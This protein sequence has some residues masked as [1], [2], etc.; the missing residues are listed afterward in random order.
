[1]IDAHREIR[2]LNVDWRYFE[3]H[4]DI[5]ADVEQQLDIL[6]LS[7]VSSSQVRVWPTTQLYAV[8]QA[9]PAVTLR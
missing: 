6:G 5:S 8:A 2:S 1:V 3:K 9:S 4:R 7:Q